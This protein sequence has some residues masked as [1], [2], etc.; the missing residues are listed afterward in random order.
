MK[1]VSGP[2]GITAVLAATL[3]LLG[4]ATATAQAEPTNPPTP[5]APCDYPSVCFVKDGKVVYAYDEVIPW[6]YLPE[7]L[8]APV[9]VINTRHESIWIGDTKGGAECVQP[10]SIVD[11]WLGTLETLRI[12]DSVECRLT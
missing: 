12:D 8:P 7:R 9:Q 2:R 1:A 4:G 3:L 6:Q 11:K 10:E 5:A